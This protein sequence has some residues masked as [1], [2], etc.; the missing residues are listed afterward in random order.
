VN[1][2]R[3]GAARLSALACGKNYVPVKL[4]TSGLEA[5]ICYEFRGKAGSPISVFV[6]GIASGSF[7]RREIGE[8]RISMSHV[9]LLV[10]PTR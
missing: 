9:R 5:E 7:D 3:V 4:P 10:E 2:D 1:M 8:Q 6:H